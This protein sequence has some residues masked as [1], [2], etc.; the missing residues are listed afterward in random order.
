MTTAG[1]PVLYRRI[2]PRAGLQW[3]ALL[4]GA[5]IAAASAIAQPSQGWSGILTAA[6]FGVTLAM[7]GAVFVA[8]QA[9]AG[10]RWWFPVRGIPLLLARTLAVP[11]AVLVLCLVVGLA[12]LYPWARPGAFGPDSPLHGKEAWLNAPL[13]LA[14][15][16]VVLVLW[17]A[18]IGRMDRRLGD[19]CQEPSAASHRRFARASIGFLVVYAVTSSVASWDWFM[20]LEP[21]WFS[22]MYS[23]YVFAGTLLGGIAAV[24]LLAL[25]LERAGLLHAPLEPDTVHDLG[26]LLFAFSTFWAYIWFCQYLLVW[27]SN[28]PEETAHY[29]ARLSG[30]WSTLFH[31]NAVLNWVVPFVALL[32]AGP[33][34]R[35]GALLQ[36]AAV[37][38][39]GRWLDV[40]LLVAPS[41]GPLPAFPLAAVAASVAVLGGMG[42]V[43]R[44]GVARSGLGSGIGSRGRP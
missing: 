28:L 37:V 16:I 13:F 15:A 27:Y 5:A 38:L 32:G 7:G 11:A 24:T 31:L 9:A 21:A 10:A 30:G 25:L 19:L 6:L 29:A 42:M 35:P 33:K 36:V 23:V 4:G 43:W 26:K 44:W 14:R 22:T 40:F 20:S 41:T 18:L 17:F 34:R 3:V 2:E 39:V 8:V 1:A 12:P